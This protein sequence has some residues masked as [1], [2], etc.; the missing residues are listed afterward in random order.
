MPKTTEENVLKYVDKLREKLCC[1]EEEIAA[2]AAGEIDLVIDVT[3]VTDA[4]DTYLLYNN[5]GVL[6][7]TLNPVLLTSTV[8]SN[9]TVTL[10]STSRLN[11]EFTGSTQVQIVNLGD[12]TTYFVGKPFKII[13]NSTNIIVVNNN[14][15]TLQRRMLPGETTRFTCTSIA[16]ATGAWY[17]ETYAKVRALNKHLH[18][19]EDFENN[20]ITDTGFTNTANAGGGAGAG[21]TMGV[22]TG[23]TS[24]QAGIISLITGTGTTARSTIQRGSTNVFF[25]GGVHVFEA[26]VY[27]PVLSTVTNEYILYIGFGDVSGA[28][29]MSDGAY[30]KY[31]RLTSVNWQMCTAN[32]GAGNRTATASATAVAAATWIKL[33]IEVNAA[34]TRV[35]YLINDTNIGNVLT[36]IPITSA[37][38][39][40]ELAKIEKSAGTTDTAFNIDYIS[41][42]FIRTTAL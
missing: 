17:V 3:E 26:Y 6:G 22:T 25:G 1:I 36:N 31:D 24:S 39:T 4:T 18:W 15:G 33:R 10:T 7:E 38:I 16:D 41:R 37:R 34:G 14:A 19:E 21:I 23:I 40:S 13:N 2:L 35:D 28:G 32:G 29:D 11:Q 20:A 30:F 5:A 27:I 42:D 9:G 12:C 8:T